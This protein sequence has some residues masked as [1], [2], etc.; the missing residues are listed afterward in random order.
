MGRSRGVHTNTLWVTVVERQGTLVDIGTNRVKAVS[1]AEKNVDT[2]R[3]VGT[4][5]LIL[6]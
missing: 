2:A 5:V 3:V 1:L 4:R 6:S